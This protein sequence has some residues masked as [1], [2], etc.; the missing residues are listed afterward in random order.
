MMILEQYRK[1]IHHIDEQIIKL[2]I[3]R[4]AIVEQIAIYKHIHSLPI[5]DPIRRKNVLSS[6]L[7]IGRKK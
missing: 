3:Q 4:F 2:L 7:L 6:V 5:Y 1:E